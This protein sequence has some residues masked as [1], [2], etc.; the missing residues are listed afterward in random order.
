MAS[1]QI[2]TIT[3]R[4]TRVDVD[5]VTRLRASAVRIAARADRRWV[6]RGA[7]DLERDDRPSSGPHRPLPRARPNV[8]LAVDFRQP[9]PSCS[10]RCAGGGHNIAG[11]AHLR[12]RP[13]D[14]PL[15]HE[16]RPVDPKRSSPRYG[17]V[18]LIIYFLSPLLR[19]GFPTYKFHLGSA[20]K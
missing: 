13:G 20:A 5:E 6:R 1:I 15:C 4:V 11:N 16:L 10:S 8:Q 12:R 2:A 14:R 18:G 19:D 17:E 7:D 9:L 3:R